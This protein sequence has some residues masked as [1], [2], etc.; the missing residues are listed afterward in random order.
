M[1]SLQRAMPE[2]VGEGR[3]QSGPL[4]PLASPPV[5]LITSRWPRSRR[6]GE[7]RRR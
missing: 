2:G 6:D 1:A 4:F 5:P 7:N 3:K